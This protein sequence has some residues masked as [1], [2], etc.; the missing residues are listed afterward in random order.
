MV[1]SG[2]PERNGESDKKDCD[3][4][5]AVWVGDRHAAEIANLCIDLIF[6]TPGILIQ[7]DLNLRLKIRIGIHTGATTA[8]L[9]RPV[10]SVL[11]VSHSVCKV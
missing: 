5:A 10:L 7:H 4:Y 11:A 1:A 3:G 6:I 8:V 2:L 9:T